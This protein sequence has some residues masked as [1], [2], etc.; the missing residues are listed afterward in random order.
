MH[1]DSKIAE[2]EFFLEQVRQSISRAP[3]TVRP[4]S[5]AFLSAARSAL[6]YALKEATSKKQ[7]HWYQDAIA[8]ADPVVKFLTDT[9]NGDIHDQPFAMQTHIGIG[10]GP[11]GLGLSGSAPTVITSGDT[12]ITWAEPPPALPP[13]QSNHMEPQITTHR[14]QFKDWPGSED[15]VAL[16]S[17]YLAEVKRIIADGRALGILTP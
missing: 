12:I 6:Q 13:R 2:A 15:V 10:M 17:H 4:Q 11:G 14:F 7:Q 3:D 9:R 16:C 1:E 5:S 8:K